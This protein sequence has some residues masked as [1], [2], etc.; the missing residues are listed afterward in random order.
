MQ[1]DWKEYITGLLDLQEELKPVSTEIE[2]NIHKDKSIR[3]CLFDIYGTL[4]ISSSGDINTFNIRTKKLKK[5]FDAAGI[6]INDSLKDEH[7]VSYLILDALK[8]IIND[9]HEESKKN[10][11]PYPEVEIREIWEKVLNHAKKNNYISIENTLDIYFL[12]LVFELVNN[13]VFPMPGMNEV[14]SGLNKKNMPLGIISNAQFYTPVIMNYFI[15]GQLKSDEY[16]VNFN[17]DLQFFSY[18]YKK[19]KPDTFLFDKVVPVLIEK[20]HIKGPHEILFVGND[21]LKDVYP[22]QKVGIKTA[23]FAGDKRSLRLR[24]DDHKVKG[25]KPDFVITDLKQLFE[26][27]E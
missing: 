19:A 16:V 11:I 15:T 8:K 20:Y 17:N 14:I 4:L 10:N 9:H 2:T 24:K 22:A 27:I 12:T 21:L 3:A 23:L 26:I 5:A 1:R 13:K 18:K 6:T 25:V 7:A